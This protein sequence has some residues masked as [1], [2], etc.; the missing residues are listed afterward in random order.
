ME[1]DTLQREIIDLDIREIV[2]EA[3]EIQ[4]LEIKKKNLEVVIEFQE[5]LPKLRIDRREA[6]KIINNL[7]SN[8]VKYNKIDG[9]III[10][11][12][13]N[14]N[15]ITFS[16]EDTGIGLRDDDREKLFQ[17]FFRAKNKYTRSISGTGLGL[18]IVKRL[19]EANHGKIEF[20]SEFDKGTKFTILFPFK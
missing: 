6:V 17:Q 15:Y 18:S 14:E 4:D 10:A 9:K 1:T 7:I 12:F 19:V 5:Q 16:V 3:L 13:V 11:A 8:A 20:D 2:A